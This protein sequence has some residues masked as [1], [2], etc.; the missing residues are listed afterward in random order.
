MCV[1]TQVKTDINLCV[2]LSIWFFWNT[3]SLAWN[4]LKRLS[5]LPSKPRDSTFPL[6]GLQAHAAACLTSVYTGT[7]DETQVLYCV[8]VSLS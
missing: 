2:E 7:G 8:F 5:W 4:S 6:L 1:G 3:F